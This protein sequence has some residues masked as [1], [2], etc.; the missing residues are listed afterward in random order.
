MEKIFEK[1]LMLPQIVEVEKK[2]FMVEE[3]NSLIAKQVEI[4]TH[5]GDYKSLMEKIK[6]S[7]NE[8]MSSLKSSRQANTN[9]LKDRLNQFLRLLEDQS[10]TPKIVEV[11]K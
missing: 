7:G 9:Q 2:V 4:D 11:V 6:N 3:I 10:R 1:I 8:L 5:Y